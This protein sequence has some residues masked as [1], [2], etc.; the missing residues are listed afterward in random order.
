M[1]KLITTVTEAR[2][3]V[4]ALKP[5][6]ASRRTY[7]PVLS[8]IRIDVADGVA[9]LLG[10]DLETTTRIGPIPAE[11]EG[12]TLLRLADLQ[13]TLKNAKGEVR[14]EATPQ[15]GDH[16]DETVSVTTS[17]GTAVFTTLPIEEYPRLSIE[18]YPRQVGSGTPCGSFTAATA[19]LAALVGAASNDDARPILTG[20]HADVKNQ[21]LVATD[22]YRLAFMPAEVHGA[23]G[24]VPNG[25]LSHLTKLA[26][27]PEVTVEFVEHNGR[28]EAAATI[29][30]VE[31]RSVTIDGEFPS[32]ERL[33]PQQY[34]TKVSLPAELVPAL[35]ALSG[36]QGAPVRINVQDETLT[37]TYVMQ[38][39]GSRTLLELPAPGYS[40]GTVAYNPE[41]LA[42]GMTMCGGTVD[43]LFT[44]H[45]KP[46][47]MSGNGILYLIMPVRTESGAAFA[48]LKQ[49][50]MTSRYDLPTPVIP[51]VVESP[52]KAKRT[53]KAEL[54]AFLRSVARDLPADVKA[55]ADRLLDAA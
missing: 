17:N 46:A 27:G 55:E 16:K 37:V 31:V 29:G 7:L 8:C 47:V 13:S 24:L 33:F 21:R 50:E 42:D 12:S 25:Y 32:Y 5:S 19:Q 4:A 6:F 23:P 40:D 2:R 22:S 44:D 45:L 1:L 54:V 28:Q 18:E 15:T 9:S 51:E 52:T 30:D 26:S 20:I 11:G 43:L 48:H 41:Y 49:A 34:D 53:G 35:R 36:G 3:W 39:V 10:T 14:I 38:D